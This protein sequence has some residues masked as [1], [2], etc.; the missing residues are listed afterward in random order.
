MCGRFTLR[1]PSE[2]ILRALE[3]ETPND[4]APIVPRYNIAP[5]QAV[6][7][8]A[9]KRDDPNR[10]GLAFLKWGLVPTW[11]DGKVRPINA[12]METVATSGMFKHALAKRRCLVPADGFIEWRAEGK[13]KI[14]F[15]FRLASEGVFAFAGLFE[16]HKEHGP[17]CCIITTTP[18]ELVQEVH[19]RMPVILQ[20][21][22]YA[23][24]LNPTTPTDD[25]LVLLTPFPADEMEAVQV[26]EYVNSA[27]HEGPDCLR[28][29][30]VLFV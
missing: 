27:K 2:H 24:W 18:N 5:S 4:T 9:L 23:K 14:P 3:V 7:A 29:P 15:H 25:L 28:E 1:T 21:H 16:T 20:P 30:V 11:S 6:A 17:T 26:S 19:D 8:V 13:Q 22:E 12:R 10:R